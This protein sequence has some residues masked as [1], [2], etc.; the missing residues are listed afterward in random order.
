M[1]VGHCRRSTPTMSSRR[2]DQLHVLDDDHR[3]QESRPGTMPDDEQ[4]AEPMISGL[5]TGDTRSST[6]NFSRMS[7]TQSALWVDVG[8]AG[9]RTVSHHMVWGILVELNSLDGC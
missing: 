5:Y 1:C 7:L 2:S 6:V 9:T 3:R 4:V 8:E